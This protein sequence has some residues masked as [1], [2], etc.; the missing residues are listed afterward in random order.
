[1]SWARDVA[2]H[3]EA[4]GRATIDDLLPH[5]RHMNRQQIS[6]AL[7]NAVH[8]GLIHGVGFVRSSVGRTRM[9]IYASGEAPGQPPRDREGTE[10]RPFGRFNSVWDYAAK[11]AA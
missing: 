7:Q 8:Y 4:N 3:I 6:G 5:F 1:M 2:A 9:Q 11:V 10:R